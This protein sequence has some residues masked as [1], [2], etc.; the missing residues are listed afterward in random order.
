MIT[1]LTNNE[2]IELFKT[3]QQ[4]N[5]YPFMLVNSNYEIVYANRSFENFSQ[6]KQDDL[7]ATLFGEAIGCIYI[8]KDGHTCGNNYYCE[9]C[10]LRNSIVN[11]LENE[12]LDEDELVREFEIDNELLIR[13]VK[14][15]SFPFK[16]KDENY[17][18]VIIT[19]SFSD[20][21]EIP[22]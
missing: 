10:S 12:V 20:I 8:K 15:L 2:I 11:S 19:D 3:Y 9:L 13:Q 5:P 14:H 21:D 4:F 17:A 6:K 16:T 22:Q 18:G 1:N 7:I